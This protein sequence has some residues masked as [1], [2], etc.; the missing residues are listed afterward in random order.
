MNFSEK[1][2]DFKVLT[3]KENNNLIIIIFYNKNT[4]N[5]QKHIP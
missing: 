4:G 1:K 2:W 3:N 5:K